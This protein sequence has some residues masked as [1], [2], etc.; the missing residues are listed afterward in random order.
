MFAPSFAFSTID[1][2]AIA[3]S[4]IACICGIIAL[5]KVRACHKALS[6]LCAGKKGIALEDIVMHN[7]KRIH[8]FDT[9]IHELFQI[10]NTINAHAHKALHK[11]SLVKFNPFHDYSGNQSFA[12]ALLNSKDNG[13]IISSIHTREGTRIYTKEIQ[14]GAPVN[15]ELTTEEKEA[16]TTAQ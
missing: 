14:N 4:V 7:N 13:M 9:E 12:L 16:I 11:V 6:A 15:N 5:I 3:F 1:I 10:S 2:V 8:E